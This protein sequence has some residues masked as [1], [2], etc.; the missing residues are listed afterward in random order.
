MSFQ[1]PDEV[2]E[3]S[4]DD[5]CNVRINFFVKPVRN[6]LY[7]CYSYPDFGNKTFVQNIWTVNPSPKRLEW[8]KVRY[9]SNRYKKDVEEATPRMNLG[10]L[11]EYHKVSPGRL[12]I[13]DSWY[14]TVF[15]VTVT[16]PESNEVKTVLKTKDMMEWEIKHRTF[17]SSL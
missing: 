14:E 12:D 7:F 1:Y 5:R 9:Y 16:N 15:D 13:V 8:I 10:Q 2:M 11:K 4:Y 3:L 6:T 17:E